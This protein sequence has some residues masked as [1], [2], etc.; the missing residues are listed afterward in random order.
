[1]SVFYFIFWKYLLKLHEH[2]FLIT[3]KEYTGLTKYFLMHYPKREDLL[4]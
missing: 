3:Q 1:M 4:V 2:F